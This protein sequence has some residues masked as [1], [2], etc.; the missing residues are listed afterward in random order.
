MNT[1]TL[2]SQL[3]DVIIYIPRDMAGGRREARIERAVRWLWSRGI[4]PGPSA[5]S[6]RL[7][8]HANRTIDGFE[9]IVRN[10]LM[11]ELKIPRQRSGWFDRRSA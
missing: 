10:R 4:Y 11:K 8:G 1:R 2:P 5:V 3:S 6:L 9:T 7:H